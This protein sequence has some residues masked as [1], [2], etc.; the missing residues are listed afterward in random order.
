M[1]LPDV[2]CFT[3]TVLSSWYF[4]KTTS[5]KDPDFHFPFIWQHWVYLTSWQPWLGKNYRSET[6]KA[7]CNILGPTMPYCLFN[8]KAESQLPT[9]L[10]FHCCFCHNRVRKK[11][12]VLTFL[13][14]VGKLMIQNVRCFKKNGKEDIFL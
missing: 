8:T 7:P 10:C 11:I 3:S 1:S 13:P 9:L 2:I 6:G 12:L 5:H 14:N 4:A